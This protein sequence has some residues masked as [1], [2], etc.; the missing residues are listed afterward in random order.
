M[1]TTYS[2]FN[3]SLTAPTRVRT[4]G[5]FNVGTEFMITQSCWVIGFRYRRPDT[6]T[7]AT[8]PT[9]AL[10]NQGNNNGASTVW[11]QE[12]SATFS[13]T[14]GWTGAGWKTAMLATPQKLIWQPTSY[15]NRYRVSTRATRFCESDNYWSTGAGSAG[16]TSGPL[17]VPNKANA[18]LTAQGSYSTAVGDAPITASATAQNWWSEVLI[19]DVD[20]RMRSNPIAAF[21]GD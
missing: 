1:A 19:S 13:L 3:Q 14:T 18:F 7:Q 2:I 6:T 8:A 9:A 5:P 16:F 20:P 12:A 21:G 11:T 4:D 10:F 17:T 15:R